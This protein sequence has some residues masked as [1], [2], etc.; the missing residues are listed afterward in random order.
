MSLVHPI[1]LC[2]IDWRRQFLDSSPQMAA[3]AKDRIR[4]V[5]FAR[6]LGDEN[7]TSNAVLGEL[8]VFFVE[9]VGAGIVQQ[10]L[11][12]ARTPTD[13]LISPMHLPQARGTPEEGRPRVRVFGDTWQQFRCLAYVCSSQDCPCLPTNQTRVADGRLGA[14]LPWSWVLGVLGGSQGVWCPSS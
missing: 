12:Y 4:S 1:C 10:M 5:S 6:L 2:R 13:A 7:A 11:P 8:G 9:S 14:W 3:V